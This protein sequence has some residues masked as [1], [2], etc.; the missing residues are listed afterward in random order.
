MEEKT[1]TPH[2]LKFILEYVE[3]SNA[4]RAYLNAGFKTKKYNVAAV[5]AMRL[6]KKPYIRKE[7]ERRIQKIASRCE[8][9]KL[10]VLK[11]LSKIAFANI[12]DL[13]EVTNGSVRIKN[14]SQSEREDLASI[15]SVSENITQHG[16]SIQIKMH[17]KI[18][19]LEKLF[20]VTKDFDED[21]S[22]LFKY[23]S[24]E[25][26]DWDAKEQTDEDSL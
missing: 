25:S 26:I 16:G 5:Q 18:K 6:L 23:K 8:V 15:A 14:F 11:E 17:D 24:R 3:H 19:A 10:R 20:E 22:S 7:I 2:E 13:V 21:L 4:T 1:L 9:T 12:A